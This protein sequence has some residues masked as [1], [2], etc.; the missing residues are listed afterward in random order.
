MIGGDVCS[1]DVLYI[2]LG[3]DRQ[4]WQGFVNTVTNLCLP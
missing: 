3:Q 1:E 2:L 4:T